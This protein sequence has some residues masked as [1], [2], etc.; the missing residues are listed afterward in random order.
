V[1]IRDLHAGVTG[2]LEGDIMALSG[3]VM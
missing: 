2:K 1:P 3:S